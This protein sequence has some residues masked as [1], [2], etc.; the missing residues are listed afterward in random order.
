MPTKMVNRLL[1]NTHHRKAT[2]SSK[3]ILGKFLNIGPSQQIVSKI[4]V[5]YMY[6]R[7]NVHNFVHELSVLFQMCK[8][9]HIYIAFLTNVEH[10]LPIFVDSTNSHIV[11]ASYKG[12]LKL[13]AGKKSRLSAEANCNQ[14]LQT[15]FAFL[16]QIG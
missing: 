8:E 2:D 11:E 15:G 1:D 12:N 13:E 16:Q 10:V 7:S 6:R 5:H 9:R 4:I 14:F 3:S